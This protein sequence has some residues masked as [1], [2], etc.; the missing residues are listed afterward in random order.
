MVFGEPVS[1][2]VVALG[3]GGVRP[4]RRRSFPLC[5][6]HRLFSGKYNAA[7]AEDLNS[8]EL[9]Q[10]FGVFTAKTR[11]YLVFTRLLYFMRY[12]FL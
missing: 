9:A 8:T 1:S 4:R 11:A 2:G 7:K 10:I 6:L 5:P 12:Y 3:G